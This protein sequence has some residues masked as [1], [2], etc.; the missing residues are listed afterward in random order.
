MRVRFTP[1]EA[2]KFLKLSPEKRAARLASK[3]RPCGPCNACCT[4][5]GVSELLKPDRTPCEH[6]VNHSTKSCGIYND[7]PFSCKVFNCAWRYEMVGSGVEDRPDHSGVIFDGG[8]AGTSAWYV[9]YVI[10]EEETPKV[11]ELIRQAS[12][13]MPVLVRYPHTGQAK[14]IA[15]DLQHRM[16]PNLIKDMN[17]VYAEPQE[18]E[19]QARRKHNIPDKGRNSE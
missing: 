6:L 15:S 10:E 8:R 18:W 19:V 12:E 5:M 17:S 14:V 11:K 1:E 13:N 3:R 16:M 7:R 2:E 9:A 4:V